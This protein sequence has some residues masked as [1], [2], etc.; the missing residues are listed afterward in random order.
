MYVQY[1]AAIIE[2]EFIIIIITTTQI[3]TA[4]PRRRSIGDSYLYEL[5]R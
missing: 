3:F 1:I 4:D 2:P 5:V